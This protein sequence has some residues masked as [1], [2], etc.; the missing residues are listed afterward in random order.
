MI[1]RPQRVV[2]ENI[3]ELAGTGGVF[4]SFDGDFKTFAGITQIDKAAQARVLWRGWRNPKG[5]PPKVHY[6]VWNRITG[7]GQTPLTLELRANDAHGLVTPLTIPDATPTQP[8]AQ[9]ISLPNGP[10][11]GFE[12]ELIITGNSADVVNK[13]TELRVYEI[14][15][16][17]AE[18]TAG[19]Q[20]TSFGF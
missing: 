13:L 11:Y 12:I 19:T 6:L 1:L 5:R 2:L 20:V 10:L 9:S 4:D 17:D 14:E 16:I 8:A 15:L 18:A 7:G 3:I